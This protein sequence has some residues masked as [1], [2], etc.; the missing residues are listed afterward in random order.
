MSLQDRLAGLH[1]DIDALAGAAARER[2]LRLRGLQLAARS[3][4]QA[5]SAA[6]WVQVLADAAA[7]LASVVCF[8]R[9][10]GGSL[11]CDA[12]RGIDVLPGVIALD[13]APAF[14]QAV[15]TRETVVALFT[16]S[17]LGVLGDAGSRRRVHLFPLS[18]RTRV[19]GVMLALADDEPDSYA[20][21]V[22]LSIAAASLEL[23]EPAGA[24]LVTMAPAPALPPAPAKT[25]PTAA[26]FAR[27]TVANWVLEHGAAIAAGRAAGDVYRAMRLPIDGALADYERAYPAQ[28]GC[29]HEEILRV[30]AVGRP[31]LLGAGYPF[32]SGGEQ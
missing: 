8:F 2:E 31:E 22:L 30:L 14:R 1:R 7:P 15:E 17:Q 5:E 9:V 3:L 24:G 28:P 23:R 16:P 29:L 32:G 6:Q 13:S 20:M 26:A 19:L 25:T 27:A 21:E 18:G 4:R 12:G 10:E 11:R